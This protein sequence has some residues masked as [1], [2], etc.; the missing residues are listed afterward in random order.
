MAQQASSFIDRLA[1]RFAGAQVTVVEP[2]GEVT[3]DVPVADWLSTCQALRDE[4]GFEQLIDL[5]GVDYMG[6]GDAEWDTSDVSSSGFSRGV[7]GRG[8]GRFGWGENP[9]RETDDGPQTMDMPSRRF[10]VIAQLRSLQHN[11]IL[12]VRTYAPDDGLPVV[13]SLCAVWPGVN[14]FEREAFDLYG[15]LFEGH[16]D[17][18]RILTDYGFVGHPFRKDFPLIGNVEVRYDEDKQRVVYEPVTSVEPRVGVPRVVRDDARFA[19][20]AGVR[21]PQEAA[22]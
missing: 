22:K 1:A 14:W 15:I 2:R 5:C 13:A 18:R 19:T 6:Y 12:A 3:L 7:E 4:L 16:P 20:A 11:L 8:V 9:E 21:A 10:A 17:L